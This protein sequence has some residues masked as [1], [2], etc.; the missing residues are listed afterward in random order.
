MTIQVME[1]VSISLDKHRSKSIL[2]LEIQEFDLV[3]TLCDAAQESCPAYIQQWVQ[4]MH[5]DF[6]DP[7]SLEEFRQVRD[8]IRQYVADLLASLA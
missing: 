5:Q 6:P 7:Q 4:L 3:I 2:D 1:E 8:D